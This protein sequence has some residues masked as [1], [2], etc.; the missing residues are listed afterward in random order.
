VDP[1]GEEYYGWSGYNYVM[2]S[3]LRLVDPDG[4]LIF[5]KDKAQREIVLTY[6][7]EQ[8]GDGIFK[9]TKRGVLKINKKELKR[10]RKAF[11]KE[12]LK[13]IEGVSKVIRSSKILEVRI[14]PDENINFSRNPRVEYENEATGE[15]EYRPAYSGKGY[16]IDK[17]DIAGLTVYVEEPRD[18]RAFILINQDAVS[19]ER[20]PGKGG[21]QTAPCESCV[22][23]H[24]L[25]DHGLDYIEKG[26]LEVQKSTE[27]QVF[28]HN[29]ALKNI[30]SD[31]RT[32]EKHNN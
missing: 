28:Y 4:R 18:T 19:K 29:L 7:G 1:L 25:L 20:Y 32:G 11:N 31:E 17:L 23:L 30:G 12:Q 14:Y 24:E 13:M 2:D 27:D 15:I 16:V 26:T 10:A 8:F 9:F 22:F 3:P 6:L 5:V 21:G